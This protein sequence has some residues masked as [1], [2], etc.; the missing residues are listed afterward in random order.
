ML[1][2]RHAYCGGRGPAGFQHPCFVISCDS[3]DPAVNGQAEEPRA[4]GGWCSPTR[5][6]TGSGGE[7]CSMTTK[8][9]LFGFGH[10]FP[11]CDPPVVVKHVSRSELPSDAFPTLFSCLW[12]VTRVQPGGGWRGTGW[13]SVSRLLLPPQHSV[14]CFPAFPAWGGGL[15]RQL[16]IPKVGSGDSGE[17]VSYK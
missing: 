8:E 12:V 1:T 17:T 6:L 7:A 4:S 11:V 14:L 3:G 13:G 15:A 9:K 2:A 16:R 5:C 10:S